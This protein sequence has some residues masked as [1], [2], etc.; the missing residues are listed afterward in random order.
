MRSPRGSGAGPGLRRWL[1]AGLL[2][3]AAPP[4]ISETLATGADRVAQRQCE[5]R[6]AQDW[7]DKSFARA[8]RRSGA[9]E[10]RVELM[11][12]VH[13][14]NAA[15]SDARIGFSL[16]VSDRVPDPRAAFAAVR[17]SDLASADRFGAGIKT[18]RSDPGV[19]V[20]LADVTVSPGW[21][22]WRSYD[23][24]NYDGIVLDAAAALYAQD[25]EI[26]DWNADSAIDS[27]A[28]VTHLVDV[29]I[30]GTGHRP[31]RLWRPGPH[32][33]VDTRIDRPGDGTL[34]WIR[35][36]DTVSLRIF[37]SR[38]AGQ[39]RLEPARVS[40]E[41]GSD[42]RIVYLEDDPRTTG[43]MGDFFGTCPLSANPDTR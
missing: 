31:L 34:I 22:A 32:L 5:S 2:A 24:T 38:F 10:G 18:H 7:L 39:P 23:D 40:C 26:D 41:A 30:S 15:L 12:P 19:T 4:A 20:Y 13:V 28:E 6:L 8:G 25:V 37:R 35:D 11:T 29:S 9:F 1:S 42:P 16:R 36:C 3:V 14:R 17:I 21:P 43:E 27:K 33:L